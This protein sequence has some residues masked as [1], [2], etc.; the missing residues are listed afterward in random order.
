MILI[1]ELP[2]QQLCD[3]IAEA[4]RATYAAVEPAARVASKSPQSKNY[5]F[6]RDPF[7]YE[8]QYCGEIIDVGMETVWYQAIPVWGMVYRGGVHEAYTHL[9][10]PLFSFLKEALRQPIA[11]FPTRGPEE[12][13]RGNLLYSNRP[14]G[15]ISTFQ[16]S[17]T[18]L[19]DGEPACYRRYVGGLI[20]GQ[21]NPKMR[22]L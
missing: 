9:K 21:H 7:R 16:G 10:Q 4:K 2:R 22:L 13:Q 15:D 19:M 11:H 1:T 12:Y 18:V 5:L 3:F 20:L 6:E 17:E 8:D 14:E